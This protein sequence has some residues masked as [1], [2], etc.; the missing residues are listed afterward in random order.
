MCCR[1]ESPQRSPRPSGGGPSTHQGLAHRH[2]PPAATGPLPM[3]PLVSPEE[4]YGQT[5]RQESSRPTRGFP[6]SPKPPPLPSPALQGPGKSGQTVFP[7]HD[8]QT[9][10][11]LSHQL[12]AIQEGGPFSSPSPSSP[13]P[14]P[15]PAPPGLRGASRHQGEAERA[16]VITAGHLCLLWF[17]CTT[18]GHAGYQPFLSVPGT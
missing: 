1:A 14:A 7:L 17:T 9:T 3:F 13:G 11:F 15:V 6:S 18:V 16:S 10:G 5:V 2:S 4:T 8:Q 12:S